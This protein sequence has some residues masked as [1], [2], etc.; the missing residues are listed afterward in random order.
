[1]NSSEVP[2]K[3]PHTRASS[4]ISSSE[5]WRE[6]TGSPLGSLWV[7]AQLEREA[8]PAGVDALG[9][10]PL[11]RLRARRGVAWWPID[12][13]PITRRRMALWPTM[14]PAFTDSVPVEAVEPLAVAGPVPG[15]ALLQRL[16][17]HAL[18]PG[19]HAA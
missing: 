8:E 3:P 10:Q 14:N 16:E 15:H 19:Q 17:R 5:A 12:R 11:H 1:M 13:S 6:G 7:V 4:T 9:Q 18:H 2:S